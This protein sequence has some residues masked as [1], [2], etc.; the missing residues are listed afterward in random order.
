MIRLGALLLAVCRTV[1]CWMFFGWSIGSVYIVTLNIHKLLRTHLVGRATV[2]AI[3]TSTIFIIYSV[4]FG[5]AW[6]MVLRSSPALKRWAISA[7]LVLIFFYFPEVFWGWHG[8]MKYELEW[9][10]VILLGII[11]IIIFS[12]P[13]HGWR[14]NYT[15]TSLINS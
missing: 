12:I 11:G 14:G 15:R 6:W 1:Y 9:W 13:Y 10:P 4:I 3:V 8:I 5:V 2:A 7:N